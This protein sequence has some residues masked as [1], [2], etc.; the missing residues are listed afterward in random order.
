MDGNRGGMRLILAAR[1]STRKTQKGDIGI[2]TQDQQGREWAEREGHTIVAVVADYKSGRI[3]P[4]DRPNLKP[5]VTRPEKMAQYDGILAFKNDRLSRGDWDDEARI[6]QWASANGKVLVIVDGPQWPPRHEG[7]RWS[8]EANAMQAAKEWEDI[9]ERVTRARRRLIDT[10]ALVGLVPVWAYASEGERY[11][12]VAVPTEAGKR[13]MPEIFERIAS[14]ETLAAVAAWTREEGIGSGK[15]SA[16]TVAKMIRNRTFMGDR[17]FTFEGKRTHLRVEPVVDADLWSRANKRLDNAPVG[18]RK[19]VSGVSALL[20]GGLFCPRCQTYRVATRQLNPPAP[21]YRIGAGRRPHVHHYYR[22]AGRYPERK[23][24]GNMVDLAETDVSV[25]KALAL[26]EEPWKEPRLI[27]GENHDMELA[28]ISLELQDLPSRDLPDAEED[29]ERARLRAERDRLLGQPRIPDRWE[30]V[31]T[32][33]T[34]GQH[35]AGLDFDGKRSMLLEHVKVYA[36]SAG[37][38][39]R[40]ESH[41]FKLRRIGPSYTVTSELNADRDKRRYKIQGPVAAR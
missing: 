25:S 9:R 14:G 24:C 30:E 1:L 29:A 28:Q 41:L 40:I 21:M 26:A 16:S 5:W 38:S 4:W 31:E 22:C 10:G 17:F 19:P 18:R 3:A 36:D 12:H 33:E 39:I 23:S 8:W 32:G 13:Y 7:D 27:K 2:T 34:V 37:P 20:T 15:I 11:S 35:W 6:R